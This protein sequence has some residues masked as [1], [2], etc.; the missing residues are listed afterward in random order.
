MASA[1]PI[2]WAALAPAIASRLLGEPNKRLSSARELRYGTH[3]SLSVDLEKGSFYDHEANAGGGMLALIQ[4]ERGGDE[5]AA[6]SPQPAAVQVESNGSFVSPMPESPT[7]TDGTQ[8]E[9]TN[10]EQP[11]QQQQQPQASPPQQQQE[12]QEQDLAPSPSSSVQS[13][14]LASEGSEQQPCARVDVE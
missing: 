13:P 14:R 9:I 4:R 10:P 1:Q 8:D 5:A 11:Q 2:D 6:L 12:Q 3:G 7:R